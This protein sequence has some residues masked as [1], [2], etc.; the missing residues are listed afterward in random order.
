M[1]QDDEMLYE[2]WENFKDLLLLC[3]HHGLQH[4]MIIQAFYNG[5]T[6]S[7]RS[8]IDVAVG[9]TLMSKIGD[10]TYNLIEEMAFNNFQWSNKRD[11]PK[12]VRDKL[13]VDALTLLSAKVDAM[14]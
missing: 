14:T 1:Q 13:K 9:G 2:A 11:Q 3:P 4:W 8:I 12:R 7:V 6:Q 5:V 10:N